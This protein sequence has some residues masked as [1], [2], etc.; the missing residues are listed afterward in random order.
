[1]NICALWITTTYGTLERPYPTSGMIMEKAV[2]GI[3]E[4][5]WDPDEEVRRRRSENPLK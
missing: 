4:K 2:V 1:M 5:D 3:P